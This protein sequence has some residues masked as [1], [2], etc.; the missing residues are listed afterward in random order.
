MAC[1]TAG[2]TISCDSGGCSG[3]LANIWLA[4]VDDIASITVSGNGE[5]SAI[6]MVA[7]KVFYN[8]NFQDQ[9]ASFTESVVVENCVKSVDQVLEFT[10]PCRNSELTQAIEELMGCCC[11]LV[12][13]FEDMQGITWLIG[14][15]NK[16]RVR[17]RTN[18]GASGAALTDA[19]SEVIT[20]GAFTTKKAGEF[21]PGPAG[22]PV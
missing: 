19:N 20:I 17:L 1:L 13:I 6:T 11:G 8:F 12:A 3:G 14:D 7:T 10:V 16:R 15:L 9:Q 21:L 2:I 4:N 22:V 5:I 18:T